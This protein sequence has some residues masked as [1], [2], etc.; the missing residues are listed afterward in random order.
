MAHQQQPNR[1]MTNKII[2]ASASP[3]RK[4]LIKKLYLTAE[5][6]P[7]DIDETELPR[8]LPCQLAQR[9]SIEKANKIADMIND[10]CY[11]IAADTVAAIGRRIMPKAENSTQIK[12]CLELYSGRRHK[13]TTGICVIRKSGNSKI[14]RK[15]SVTTALKFKRLTKEEIDYYAS[16]DEGVG[17]AGG[18][19]IQGYIQAYIAF[20]SGSVSNVIGLPL[21]ETKNALTSLGYEFY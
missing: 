11:I 2:L 16:L 20:V 17:K 13:V 3:A 21:L 7:A 15:K 14:L 9:L 12:E 6:M 10:D 19:A 5:I 18:Y 4:E 8:E 1:L